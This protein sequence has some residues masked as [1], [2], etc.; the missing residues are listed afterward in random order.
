MGMRDWTGPEQPPG[1]RRVDEVRDL[2]EML[3]AEWVDPP[4]RCERGIPHGD[5]DG[6]I[7]WVLE[8]LVTVA[9]VQGWRPSELADVLTAYADYVRNAVGSCRRR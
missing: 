7:N 5:A 9:L 1:M 2:L 3:I 8:R 6:G 4:K